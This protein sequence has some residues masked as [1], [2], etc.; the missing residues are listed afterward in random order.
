MLCHNSSE[1]MLPE[2]TEPWANAYNGPGT[3]RRDRNLG[4]DGVIALGMAIIT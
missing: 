1:F 4:Q 2:V 3:E